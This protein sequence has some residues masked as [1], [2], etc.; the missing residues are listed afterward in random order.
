[1][2]ESVTQSEERERLSE[3]ERER[4]RGRERETEKER[5]REIEYVS[6]IMF[7]LFYHVRTS[8]YLVIHQYDNFIQCLF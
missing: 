8:T 1:M 3:R 5:Q 4:E 2:R 7:I 6:I